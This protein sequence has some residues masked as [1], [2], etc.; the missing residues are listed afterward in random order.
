MSDPDDLS[1]LD[2]TLRRAAAALTKAEIPFVLGGSVACWARGGPRVTNDVD[3]MI[4]PGDAEAALAALRDA[5][6]APQRP[7]ESWLLKANDPDGVWVDLIFQPTGV[8]IDR[9]YIA[10]CEEM[11]VLAMQM[12]VMSVNDVLVSRLLAM[13]EHHLDYTSHLAIVRALREQIDWEALAARVGESPYARGF[14]GLVRELG[15]RPHAEATSRAGAV[16][17]RRHEP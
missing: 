12:R 13:D 4:D 15:I 9:G 17:V 14:L 1:P 2:H 3:M 16:Q 6:L 10:G 5:G 11:A 8:T 7:P